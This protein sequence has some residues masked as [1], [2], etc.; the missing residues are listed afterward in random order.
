MLVFKLRILH[1]IFTT[2]KKNIAELFVWGFL[3]QNKKF[4]CNKISLSI[5]NSNFKIL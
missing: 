3:K 5:R 4:K 2:V 1:V